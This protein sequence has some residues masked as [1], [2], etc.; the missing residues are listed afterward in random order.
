MECSQAIEY[1]LQNSVQID[2]IQMTRLLHFYG[3]QK[4]YNGKKDILLSLDNTIFELYM[5][6]TGTEKMARTYR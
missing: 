1:L 6:G 2:V 3:M 4:Q 5:V